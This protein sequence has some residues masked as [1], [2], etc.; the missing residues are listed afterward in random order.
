MEYIYIVVENG[1][2]HPIAYNTYK[3]AVDS[4]KEKYKDVLLAHTNVH[5]NTVDGI[6]KLY[7]ENGIN[8]EIH[9]LSNY[10]F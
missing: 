7:I 10:R 2:Q 5:E 6:T 3:L 1:Q 9:R 4:I 8:I